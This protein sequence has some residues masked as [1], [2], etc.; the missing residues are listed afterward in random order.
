MTLAIAL[1][2]DVLIVQKRR[3]E[4]VWV[5]HEPSV[6]VFVACGGVS[7]YGTCVNGVCTAPCLYGMSGDQCTLTLPPVEV[8]L[9]V[10]FWPQLALIFSVYQPK[11]LCVLPLLCDKLD[12][13][14]LFGINLAGYDLTGPFPERIDTAILNYLAQ[15]QRLP[16]CNY[17]D[18]TQR[19]V[20]DSQFV[21][22]PQFSLWVQHPSRGIL[23]REF[24]L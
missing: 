21:P 2:W 11:L 20:F 13:S 18:T 3:V 23:Y 14:R 6:C 1:L 16:G 10:S 12:P 7:C 8:Q 9:I 24:F 22:F 19:C 5:N 17:Q 15:Y 4:Y